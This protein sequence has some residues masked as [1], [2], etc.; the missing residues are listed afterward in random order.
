MNVEMNYWPAEVWIPDLDNGSSGMITL[1]Q[2]M[3]QFDGKRILLLSAWP[4]N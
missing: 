4:T 1:Q 2:M 3:I